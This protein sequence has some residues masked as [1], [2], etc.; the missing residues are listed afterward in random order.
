MKAPEAGSPD[1]RRLESEAIGI[2]REA[3]QAFR[4]PVLLF[5]AG[6]DSAVILRLAKKAFAPAVPPFP[7]LHVDTTWKFPEAYEYRDRIAAE[8]GM[9]CSFTSTAKGRPAESVRSATAQ[10]P[11][12]G[13]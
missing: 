3:V 4:R 8:S 5:S 6:K 9:N 7:L 2:L 12:T 10:K 1:L 11:I 13:S